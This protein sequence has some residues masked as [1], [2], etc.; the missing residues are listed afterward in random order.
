MALFWITLEPLIGTLP[1]SSGFDMALAAW[2]L[3][4]G[5]FPQTDGGE[6]PLPEGAKIGCLHSRGAKDSPLLLLQR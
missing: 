1:V 4:H 6:R 5:A 2:A 3:R